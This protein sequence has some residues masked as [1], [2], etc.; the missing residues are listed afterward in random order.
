MKFFAQLAQLNFFALIGDKY[1]ISAVSVVF[2]LRY[3]SAIFRGVI[4]KCVNPVDEVK[5][6]ITVFKGPFLK[7]LK[8]VFS[9]PFVTYLDSI[10]LVSRWGCVIAVALIYHRPPLGKKIWAVCAGF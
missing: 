2:L 5:L 6:W 3:E 10:K 4:S 7:I 9:E 8:T 1:C